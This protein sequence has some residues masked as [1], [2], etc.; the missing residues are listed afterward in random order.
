MIL[1]KQLK[2]LLID[3]G[4]VMDLE[5]YIKFKLVLQVHGLVLIMMYK[6]IGLMLDH[7][8]LVEGMIK[9]NSQHGMD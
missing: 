4:L 6:G 5:H 9:I 8:K 1:L 7:K 2:Y 3:L